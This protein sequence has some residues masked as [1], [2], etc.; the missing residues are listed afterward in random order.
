MVSAASVEMGSLPPPRNIQKQESSPGEKEQARRAMILS[1]VMDE[2]LK[3]LMQ[4]SF[5][6]TYQ[7]DASRVESDARVGALS[8]AVESQSTHLTQIQQ[9]QD[10]M[11]WRLAALEGH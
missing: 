5:E 1:S 4:C 2:G 6:Q 3:M 7:A 11:G 9:R 10:S 8:Q